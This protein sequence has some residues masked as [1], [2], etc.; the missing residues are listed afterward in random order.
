MLVDKEYHI[1]DNF[2]KYK[3]MVNNA[4]YS[5]FTLSDLGNIIGQQGVKADV[6]VDVKPR[7]FVYL[8]A[9]IASG[10]FV[11]GLLYLVSKKY[12]K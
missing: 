11:G 3:N 7:V 2:V 10:I 4:E 5:N 6:Q 12:I 1:A 8:A 9:G